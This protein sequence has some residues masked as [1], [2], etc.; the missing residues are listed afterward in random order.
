MSFLLASL[1]IPD[2]FVVK[3]SFHRR[4]V[5]GSR[6]DRDMHGAQIASLFSELKLPRE[7]S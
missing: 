2:L 7:L 4:E 1:E 5:Q 3:F 6:T